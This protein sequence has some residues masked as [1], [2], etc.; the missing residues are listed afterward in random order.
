[1]ANYVGL[2]ANRDINWVTDPAV[3]PMNLFIAHKIDAFLSAAPESQELRDRRIGH[4]LVNSATD[5]PWS[6]YFCCMLFTRTEF[7]QKYP[8]ATKRVIR[9]ILKATDLCA[10]E[11]QRMARQMVEQG[12]TSRYDYALQSLQELPYDVWRSYDPE[13]T[14]RFYSLR[15]HEAGFTQ[16]LPQQIIAKHTDWRF[17]NE[18]KSELKA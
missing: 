10:N 18:L 15:L 9:A 12:F 3:S 8:V 11:P 1:M 5:R 17:L 7:V 2:D 6:E 13:D 16:F 4:S 14:V